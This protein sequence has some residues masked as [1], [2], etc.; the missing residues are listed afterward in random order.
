MKKVVLL[1]S[2]I[3]VLFFVASCEDREESTYSIGEIVESISIGYGQGDSQDYVTQDLSLPTGTTLDSNITLSWISQ[4][5][6]VIDNSGTVNRTNQ[7][8]LV[9]IAYTVDYLGQ[10]FSQTLTFKVIGNLQVVQTSYEINYFFENIEDDQYTLVES[11]EIDSTV[12]QNVYVNPENEEGF[13]LNTT[14]STLMG[15]T[16][17]D[18]VI[19][20][21][22]YFDRNVYSIDLYDGTTLL[23]TIDVK[24]G[25]VISLDDPMKQDY[26]FVEWR[27]SSETTPFNALTPITSE[28]SLKAIFQEVSDAY[29]YTG[30]YQG[31]AG[32][33][34]D[35]LIAF[36][37]QISNESFS[38]VTYGDARYMLDDTDADPLNS[39]NVILVYLGTSISGVWDFG[40]TWNREHVWPQSFLGVS[41][42]NEA[43]NT[44][45]D[46]QNLKPSDPGENSSRSNKYYGNTTTSQTYAPR[47]E[48]KGDIA[49]ILF[50]MDIMYS[51]LTLIYANEGNVYEMGNLEV[52]LAWHELDPVDTFEMNRNNLIEGL[53]GN[54]NPF[55]DHPE[56]VDKIY[57]NSNELSISR[58]E[59]I[60]SSMIEVNFNEI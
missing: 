2:L 48:V 58:V 10:S 37:H 15:R 47:D 4:N 9:D 59:T 43:V 34:E 24:H 17:V 36:L 26:N 19:S 32:L 44:A 5:P 31:A 8:E 55:I 42:S 57:Q 54:R 7:D 49:R 20:L 52:L 45:S 56:F 29:V 12:N 23:D 1:F 51:E 53:Q 41:A 28:F 35:D 14:L 18:E 30:Y 38:G 11:I 40:A 27:I 22:V 6:D 39:N 33:Y 13:T 50:Y 3:F 60:L 21:D 46:L 16:S 25:D